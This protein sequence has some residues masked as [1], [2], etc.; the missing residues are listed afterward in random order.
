MSKER[1]M[2]RSSFSSPARM[3]VIGTIT[4]LVGSFALFAAAT[5]AVATTDTLRTELVTV[6][7]HD[8]ATV[9]GRSAVQHRLQRAA[10]RVCTIDD[11]RGSGGAAARRACVE[12]AVL[13]GR[14][15]M[16][17]M[18]AATPMMAAVS[19]PD[20]RSPSATSPEEPSVL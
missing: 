7:S 18:L 13:A 20:L 4:V 15:Q 16:A 6:T 5:P 14:L 12:R 2:N 19:Y 17:A 10:V 9:H 1:D 8:L 3:Q 11:Q